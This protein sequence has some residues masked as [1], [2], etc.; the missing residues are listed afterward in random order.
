MPEEKEKKEGRAGNALR[1]L[2]RFPWREEGKRLLRGL[3]RL[4]LLLLALWCWLYGA[5]AQARL[6]RYGGICHF[7]ASSLTGADYEDFLDTEEKADTSRDFALYAQMDDARLQDPATH[8][9]ISVDMLLYKGDLQ[10]LLPQSPALQEDDRDGCILDERLAY[11]LFGSVN[12][13]GNS[14]ECGGK[15]YAVR[16]VI[17]S[18]T[19]LFAAQAGDEDELT[20][21]AM[22]GEGDEGAF[23]IRHAKYGLSERGWQFRLLCNLGSIAEGLPGLLILLLLFL[24]VERLKRRSRRFPMRQMLWMVVSFALT[25]ALALCLFALI[26]QDYIPSRWS[27]FG[28]FRTLWQGIREQLAA[29]FMEK[30]TAA[31]MGAAAE[32]ARTLSCLVSLPLLAGAQAFLWRRREE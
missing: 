10:L 2:L 17:Q 22:K 12:V 30:K 1:R 20:M 27:D 18:E 13:L 11:E 23:A 8:R 5:M 7:S 3:W 29:F 19:P 26:P 14:V 24:H 32:F 4:S 15:E 16:A 25:A 28:H 6:E 21:A 31:D 9:A